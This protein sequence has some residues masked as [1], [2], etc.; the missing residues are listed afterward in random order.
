MIVVV[1]YFY[2]SLEMA[3]LQA[4]QIDCDTWEQKEALNFS[5]T[6]EITYFSP[7]RIG[8]VHCFASDK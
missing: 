1:L 3:L 2:M 8:F 7:S 5:P 4:I 6:L